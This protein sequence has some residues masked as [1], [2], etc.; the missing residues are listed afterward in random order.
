MK[1]HF[2]NLKVLY[3]KLSANNII[4]DHR[5][6]VFLTL[7]WQ[8]WEEEQFQHRRPPS[9]SPVTIT[10]DH[11]IL[12]RFHP[13]LPIFSPKTSISSMKKLQMNIPMKPTLD[14]S[15]LKLKSKTPYLIFEGTFSKFKFPENLS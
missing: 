4:F 14:L 10:P 11:H 1:C 6:S 13:S 12:R 8:V 9:P 2:S 15:L 5:F 3:N 7:L